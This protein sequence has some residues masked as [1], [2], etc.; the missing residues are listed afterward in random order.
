MGLLGGSLPNL[1]PGPSGFIR[2]PL[3]RWSP[4]CYVGLVS[5]SP[6]QVGYD[7]EPW[8]PWVVWSGW[9]P[10]GIDDGGT[11]KLTLSAALSDPFLNF[12][13]DVGHVEA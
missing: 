2:R 8:R 13:E 10:G 7:G 9:V 5:L 3:G 11:G 6:G 12:L 1:Q 4:C